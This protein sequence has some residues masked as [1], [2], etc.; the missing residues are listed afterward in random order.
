MRESKY[1]EVMVSCI[2]VGNK[3]L[4]VLGSSYGWQRS[5]HVCEFQNIKIGSGANR[6]GIRWHWGGESWIFLLSLKEETR[7]CFSVCVKVKVCR[8]D[9]YCTN[10]ICWLFKFLV[11][12]SGGG[13]SC[14]SLRLLFDVMW[15]H[16]VL[17]YSTLSEKSRIYSKFFFFCPILLIT[18]ES[19]F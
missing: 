10:L 12:S 9:N 3:S 5:M 11:L 7:W 17:N 14:W 1:Q 18:V 13:G 4:K 6:E 2:K 19:K 8:K 16:V 15:T